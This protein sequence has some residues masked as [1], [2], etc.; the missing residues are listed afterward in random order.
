MIMDH[1]SK[2]EQ[3]RGLS[4]R[5]D[6]AID[7]MLTND[8][9]TLPSGRID[10]D[11]DKLYANRMHYTASA[12]PNDKNFEIHHRYI[13]IQVIV[14]GHEG[15]AL[16]PMDVLT[17]AEDRP[18]KDI[19]FYAGKPDHIV[20]MRENTFM[21]LYP[22]EAHMPGLAIDDQAAVDKIVFKVAYK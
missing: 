10:I 8:L 12:F 7:F 6:Q 16:A 9:T 11:G 14:S 4:T 20:M 17:E 19:T 21:L 22:G 5:I 18:D 15:I 2:L 13:D 3:Y 1:L